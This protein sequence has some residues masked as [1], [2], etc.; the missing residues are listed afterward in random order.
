MGLT[1]GSH[2]KHGSAVREA[3]QGVVR[4]DYFVSPD[5]AAGN[6]GSV[7]SPWPL[8]KGV[9]ELVPGD[10]LY[11]RGGSYLGPVVLGSKQATPSDPIVIQSFPGEHATIDGAVS[12]G[13]G[14]VVHA[15]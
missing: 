12:Q 14:K 10:V 11:L 3:V 15:A 9:S 8:S 2:L 6:D 4:M 7:G 1:A 13:R 5:G